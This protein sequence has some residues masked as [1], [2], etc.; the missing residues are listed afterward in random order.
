MALEFAGRLLMYRR[1]RPLQAI[2]QRSRFKTYTGPRPS[3][4]INYRRGLE[5]RR[6]TCES[7]STRWTLA[8]ED[9]PWDR[10]RISACSA[11]SDVFERKGSVTGCRRRAS[12]NHLCARR[13]SERCSTG[14]STA[15]TEHRHGPRRRHAMGRDEG[16]RPSVYRHSEHG[17]ARARRSA[18]PERLRH[19]ATL[20]SKPGEFSDRPVSTHSVTME[21]WCRFPDSLAVSLRHLATAAATSVGRC[22]GAPVRSSPR[23]ESLRCFARLTSFLH[24]ARRQRH[25]MRR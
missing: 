25:P 8:S 24:S 3:S 10:H 18:F 21:V 9:R 22:R 23:S 16:G 5:S 2:R 13:D 1:T 6:L 7:A 15:A 11:A 19:D 12:D 20:L 17:S 14:H 4:C